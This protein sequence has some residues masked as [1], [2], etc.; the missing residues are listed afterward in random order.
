MVRKWKKKKYTKYSKK[1]KFNTSKKTLKTWRIYKYKNANSQAKQ[2]DTLNKKVNN[3][4]KQMKPTNLYNYWDEQFLLYSEPIENRSEYC[5]LKMANTNSFYKG[6]RCVCKNIIWRLYVN[7]LIQQCTDADPWAVTRDNYQ[8]IR[9]GYNLLNLNQRNNEFGFKPQ[10]IR[11]V[12]YQVKGNGIINENNERIET[13]IK[14]QNSYFEQFTRLYDPF[15]PGITDKYNILLNK[16]YTVDRAWQQL[17]FRF[18]NVYLRK[19]QSGLTN[20]MYGK[21]FIYCLV[22]VPRNTG[23]YKYTEDSPIPHTVIITYFSDI[24]I[25]S[26][27]KIRYWNTNQF[28]LDKKDLETTVEEIKEDAKE[29]LI[30]KNVTETE[31]KTEKIS[32]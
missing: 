28:N 13:E 8:Y 19:F 14:R 5:F 16:V 26:S 9:N 2:I 3:M 7:N 15:S 6:D 4:F 1:K 25:E 29:D 32:N 17:T 11:V 23:F 20:N 12:F 30:N 22:Y 18:N 31:I 21:G 27:V 24:K 10:K